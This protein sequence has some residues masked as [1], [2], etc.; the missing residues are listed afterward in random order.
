MVAHQKVNRVAEK[1]FHDG[2]SDLVAYRHALDDRG[3]VTKLQADRIPPGSPV[4]GGALTDPVDHVTNCQ[5]RHDVMVTAR[6]TGTPDGV[7]MS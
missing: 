5:V 1:G 2:L 4:P 7:F 6:G 3:R